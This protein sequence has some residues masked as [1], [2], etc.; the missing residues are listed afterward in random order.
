VTRLLCSAALAA[1]LLPPL[2]HSAPE[3]AS[4]T[5]DDRQKVSFDLVARATPTGARLGLRY[6]IA[7]GWHIYWEN[8]GDS[9]MATSAEVEAPDGWSPGDLLYPGPVSFGGELVSYGY[10]EEVTLFV[11]VERPDA[12]PGEVTVSS[13]WLVCREICEPESGEASLRIGQPSATPLPGE[14]ALPRAPADGDGVTVA[15]AGHALTITVADGEATLFPT[16]DLELA[17]G[18]NRPSFLR[19][20]N[21]KGGAPSVLRA[22]LPADRTAALRGVLRI[23]RA[24]EAT[25]LDLTIPAPGAP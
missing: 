23:E 22:N 11:D 1:L 17:L 12:A 21:A 25:F 24:G 9:G 7:P 5:P 4:E 18:G 15:V 20:G 13:R 3:P 2:A 6:R 16:V 14:A 19:E 8:P 10:S